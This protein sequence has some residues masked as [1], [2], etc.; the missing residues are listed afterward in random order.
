M[1]DS[2]HLVRLH[3]YNPAVIVDSPLT[4]TM[5]VRFYAGTQDLTSFSSMTAFHVQD[6]ISAAAAVC[7]GS[8]CWKTVSFTWS[9]K[10]L[11]AATEAGSVLFYF[12]VKIWQFTHTRDGTL[13]LSLAASD[14]IS[15][16]ELVV[17]PASCGCFQ[18]VPDTSICECV[19]GGLNLPPGECNGYCS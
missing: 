14:A 6:F 2:N 19:Q 10:A 17:G 15:W 4:T 18:W 7:Q 9:G 5:Q 16:V 11:S 13:S 12:L 8:N 1:H 3:D